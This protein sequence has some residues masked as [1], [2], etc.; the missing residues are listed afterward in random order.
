VDSK[1][2]CEYLLTEFATASLIADFPR[3]AAEVVLLAPQM[4]SALADAL[5][6]RLADFLRDSIVGANPI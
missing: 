6:P 4:I 1:V 3:N 2:V 5:T